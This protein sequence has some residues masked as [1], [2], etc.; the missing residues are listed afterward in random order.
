MDTALVDALAVALRGRVVSA[1]LTPLRTDGS[2]DLPALRAYAAE[3]ERRGVGGLAPVAHTGRGAYLSGADRVAVV[4]G[5]REATSVPL[6]AG[7]PTSDGGPEQVI[8]EAVRTGCEL[9]AAGADGLLLFPPR[10]AAGADREAVTVALHEEVAERAGVPVLAFV[11]YERASGH[12]YPPELVARLVALPGVAGV[13][14]A[15]LDDAVACQDVIV[16][17]RQVRPSTL[18]L[19]GEDRMMGPSLMW[20][21][22]SALLGIAAALPEWSVDVM[23]AWTQGDAAAFLAAS[24]RLDALARWTF[25]EPM[26]GY[27]QRMAWLAGWQGL[28][29][30]VNAADRYGPPL[31]PDARQALI[32]GVESLAASGS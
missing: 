20:G 19:T 9:A 28:M 27:V 10:V 21:A 2:V 8:A 29:P 17:A 5:C 6:L 18:V 23:R 3:L 4:R 14:L 13:K 15:L 31:A 11:L 24:R 7:V 1:L 16:A 22:D 30:D 25:R 12:Q 32:A 26:E